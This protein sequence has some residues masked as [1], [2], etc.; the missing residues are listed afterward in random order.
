MLAA[1]LLLLTRQ[2]WPARQHLGRLLTVMAGLTIGFPLLLAWA[3]Q[4]V[5]AAHAA[6]IF[7]L[8]PLATAL[9]A[10]LRAGERPTLYFWL[11]GTAGSMIVMIFAWH[12]GGGRFQQADWALFGAVVLTALSYAD[13][14]VLARTLGG[15][16]VISW[17]LTLAAPVTGLVT[18]LTLTARHGALWQTLTS[19]LVPTSALLGFIYVTICSQWLGFFAWYRALAL[20]GVARI[21]QLQL[22]MP[23]VTIVAAAL[24]LG[25]PLRGTTILTALAVCTTV[26]LGRRAEIVRQSGVRV[27]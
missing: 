21:S 13:G 12:Q 9:A 11:S 14:A 24:L 5:A 22:L 10:C 23:F 17:A 26:V 3:L 25:E 7:A 2:P 20:G 19:G 4:F 6:A 15:W 16:Q 18:L 27:L 8:L 1:P